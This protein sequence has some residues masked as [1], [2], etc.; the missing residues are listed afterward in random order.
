M[1]PGLGSKFSLAPVI[2]C[3]G[4]GAPQ[5]WVGIGQAGRGRA[6]QVQTG[7]GAAGLGRTGKQGGGSGKL[8]AG[9][10]GTPARWTG[11]G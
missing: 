8:G 1:E 11:W 10:S 7:E 6:G 3:I 4:E 9:F 5:G 2:S